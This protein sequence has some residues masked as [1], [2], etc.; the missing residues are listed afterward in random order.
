M[1]KTF[2]KNLA[3][4]VLIFNLNSCSQEEVISKEKDLFNF[5]KI[6][7]D[8]SKSDLGNEI[9]V[10]DYKD[11]KELIS[12]IESSFGLIIKDSRELIKNDSEV[13]DVFIN[14]SFKDGKATIS[15]ITEIDTKN[16]IIR[17]S[18]KYDDSKNSY[19]AKRGGPYIADLASCP[20]EYSQ[21]DS[22]S[23]VSGP[24]ECVGGAVQS[25]LSNNISGI[26]DCA[27]IQV[28]VGTFTTKVCGKTC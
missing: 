5:S 10:F 16:D 23:N 7:I 28:Q 14:V 6:K 13:S 18:F 26:G 2:I 3:L 21:V 11:K 22:C 12:K 4:I 17:Q 27:N 19:D 24:E 15:E 9:K 20:N 25:Y 1:K 8:L